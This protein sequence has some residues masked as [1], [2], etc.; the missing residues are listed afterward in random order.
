MPQSVPKVELFRKRVGCW[1]PCTCHWTR[2][3]RAVGP[4]QP[5]RVPKG[6]SSRFGQCQPLLLGVWC[7]DA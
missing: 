6:A 4:W 7:C 1:F 3:Q 5:V 2:R